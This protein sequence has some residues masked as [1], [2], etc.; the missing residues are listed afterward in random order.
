MKFKLV[1]DSD[2]RVQSHTEIDCLNENTA[3]TLKNDIIRQIQRYYPKIT[4]D[5]Q[6]YILHHIDG[7]TLGMP[8]YKD[9]NNLVL[10]PKIFSATASGNDLHHLIHWLKKHKDELNQPFCFGI[11]NFNPKTK[12]KVKQFSLMDLVDLLP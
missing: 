9:V 12:P 2:I 10:I 7:A 6:G 3:Q 11:D 8:T 4:I 5:P 1:E